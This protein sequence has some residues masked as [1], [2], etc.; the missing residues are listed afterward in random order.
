MTLDYTFKIMLFWIVSRSNNCVYCLGHQQHKLVA[1]GLPDDRIAA[2]DGDWTQFSHAERA[3]FALARKLTVAPQTVTDADIDAV[4]AHYKDIQVQEM[5]NLVAGYNAMNRWTGP[6]RL[7]Q[8]AFRNYRTPTSPLAATR[9][10]QTAPAPEGASG[11]QCR[12]A[13]NPRR[14][15]VTYRGRGEARRVPG[16]DAEVRAHR[17]VDRPR[18][19][20]P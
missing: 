4:K 14:A 6:L 7:T 18:A 1:F 2:L 8:Q 11:T 15:R 10:T 9:V 13:V 16:P 3:A 19:P 5:I 17:G 20:A 12:P